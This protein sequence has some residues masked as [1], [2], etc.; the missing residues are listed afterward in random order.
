[1]AIYSTFAGDPGDA[2][3]ARV[4]KAGKSYTQ[5]NDMWTA[6]H[7]PK[8]DEEPPSLTPHSKSPY[9]RPG[10]ATD[11][12]VSK[13]VN[14]AIPRTVSGFAAAFF[15][16]AAFSAPSVY[17]DDTSPGVALPPLHSSSPAAISLTSAHIVLNAG[18]IDLTLNLHVQPNSKETLT[19]DMPRFGWLGEGEPYPDRQFPEL[20]FMIDGAPAT[21]KSKDKAFAGSTD[22]TAILQAA[23][24]DPFLI[25][26][27]PPFVLPA[28]DAPATLAKL[29]QLGA[30][31]QDGTDFL[32][33]WKAQRSVTLDVGANSNTV[34][35][36]YTARP[37]Y[38][39]LRLSE[40]ERP[41]TL[42]RYC[43]SKQALATR[44]EHSPV[45]RLFP[46]YTYSIPASIDSKPPASATINASVSAPQ[47]TS[48]MFIAFCGADSKAVTAVASNATG[49]ALTD[50]QGTVHIL[51]IDLGTTT[52]AN[53]SL[54][55]VHHQ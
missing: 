49:A 23:G 40:I 16:A 15:L 17:A 38:A 37:G 35:L 12:P 13:A 46:I 30:V 20:K 4:N 48:R 10:Q 53:T 43:L 24:I 55:A 14:A 54:N 47:K 45:N 19:I 39:L 25:T 31:E 21:P 42:A 11:L 27:T 22:I 34:S 8:V 7:V 52:A 33:R 41:A 2:T 18:H 44:L 3:T 29:Q 5:T 28:H 51:A 1:M 9:F 6:F 50:A 36:S 26:D 32:A